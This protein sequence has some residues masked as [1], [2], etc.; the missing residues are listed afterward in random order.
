MAST[1]RI[2][3]YTALTTKR[4]YPG[5]P[6][7]VEHTIIS[8]DEWVGSFPNR[9]QRPGRA[10]AESAVPARQSLPEPLS[11]LQGTGTARSERPETHREVSQAGGHRE[12]ISCHSLRH[13]FGAYRAGQSWCK[14]C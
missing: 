3:H 14:V 9:A 2:I 6:P 13:I 7:I 1:V 12:K 4:E 8:E 11:L 10:Q 5:G